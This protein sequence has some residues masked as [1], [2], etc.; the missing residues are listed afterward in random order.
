MKNRII[1]GGKD[2]QQAGVRDVRKCSLKEVGPRQTDVRGCSCLGTDRHLL[3]VLCLGLAFGSIPVREGWN[4]SSGV[5]PSFGLVG[6]CAGRR[7]PKCGG[8]KSG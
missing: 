7:E 6:D 4:V 3:V 2:S 1:K 5:S 8:R